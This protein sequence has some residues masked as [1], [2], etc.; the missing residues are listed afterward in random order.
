M[1]NAF[2][3][4]MIDYEPNI[5]D[6][7]DIYGYIFKPLRFLFFVLMPGE[8]TDMRE[9]DISVSSSMTTLDWSA[10]IIIPRL[11]ERCSFFPP[12]HEEHHN[13]YAYVKNWDKENPN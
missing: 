7:I 12:D 1:R 5:L 2:H 8:I 3:Q 11:R 6:F 4:E 10:E 9:G 13:S